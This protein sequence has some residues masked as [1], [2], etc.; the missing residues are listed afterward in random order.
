MFFQG[1]TRPALLKT[2]VKVKPI[3][4]LQNKPR[5]QAVFKSPK[6]SWHVSEDL[7]IELEEF[8]CSM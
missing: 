4:L 8:T 7:F 2:F 6:K 1:V 5:Y 3:K